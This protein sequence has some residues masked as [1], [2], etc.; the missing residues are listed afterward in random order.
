[1]NSTFYEFIKEGRLQM[2]TIDGGALVAETLH[3][4]GMR[5]IFSVSG[6]GMATIYRRCAT[7]GIDI[8][9][10]RHEGAAAFMAD[11]TARMTGQ[12]GICMDSYEKSSSDPRTCC[13]RRGT[14]GIN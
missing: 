12:P 11:A 13:K 3:R 6:S 10:T 2:T 14:Y 4:A 9:H 8:I 1:M 5:R 7:A